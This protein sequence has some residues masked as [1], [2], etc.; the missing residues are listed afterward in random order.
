[1]MSM[2]ANPFPVMLIA[3]CGSVHFRN[4]PGR[5][6][7]GHRKFNPIVSSWLCRGAPGLMPG[8]FPDGEDYPETL[9]KKVM[10]F[11]LL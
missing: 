4:A 2:A 6:V 10:S 1:M 8:A 11:N 9:Y 5:A 3:H 7:F